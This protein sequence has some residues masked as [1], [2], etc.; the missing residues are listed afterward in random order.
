MSSYYYIYTIYTHTHYICA[1]GVPDYYAD[2][3]Y[4]CVLILHVSSQGYMYAIQ[5]PGIGTADDCCLECVVR[6]VTADGSIPFSAD[7]S[8]PVAADGSIV[9]SA[10]SGT[11]FT[12]FT[13]PTVHILTP[14]S[15][16][17]RVLSKGAR[18]LRVPHV[19]AALEELRRAQQSTAGLALNEQQR[20]K[21]KKNTELYGRASQ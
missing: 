7:G 4:I 20:I 11:Q 15:T 1:E 16:R 19:A 12:C 14:E 17:L 2:V 21:K 3:Y 5:T 8:T 10:T 6:Q 9:I 13:S 18:H